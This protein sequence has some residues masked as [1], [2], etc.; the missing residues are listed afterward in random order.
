VVD[1]LTEVPQNKPR[2]VI[3]SYQ[4][5]SVGTYHAALYITFH[6][7]TKPYEQGFTVERELRGRAILRRKPVGNGEASTAASTAEDTVGID[8][9][10]IT[11]SHDFGLELS[12]LW[13]PSG[14]AETKELI[15]TKSSTN[16]TVSFKAVRIL[17]TD[18]SVNG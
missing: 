16:P 7:R 1:G 15:I 5:S 8:G 11:V 10:G 9:T 13:P 3:V 2:K 12:A 14:E 4:P 18:D 17:S 6:D